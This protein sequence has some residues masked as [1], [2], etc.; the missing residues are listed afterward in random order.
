MKS[1]VLI[2]DIG[3]TKS[4]WWFRTDEDHEL[5]LPGYHPVWHEPIQGLRLFERLRAETAGID[6]AALW[7]YGAGVID[8][9]SHDQVGAHAHHFFPDTTLYIQS[10]LTGAAVAACGQQPGTVIILGTGSHAAIWDGHNIAKQ[11]TSLGYILGDEGGGCDLGKSLLKAYFYHEMPEVLAREMAVL[12]PGG[13]TQLL[14]ELRNAAAPNQYLASFA[15]VAVAFHDHVWVKAMVG[16]RLHLFIHHHLLPL[17]PSGEIHIVGSIGCIFAG[18]IGQA[19]AEHGLS[20]G[21]LI[22]DPS[23]RLFERHLENG[24]NEK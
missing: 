19:L 7:Y 16:E 10:D 23:R 12:L 11:A 5:H 9:V 17:N 8:Q 20:V 6:F 22:P 24:R 13:R 4:S 14:Q 2:G 15:R 18:L 21:N 3:S 1:A